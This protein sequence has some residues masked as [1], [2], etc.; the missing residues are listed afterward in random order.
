MSARPLI[1]QASA[2]D[3]A[4]LE[5]SVRMCL[6]GLAQPKRRPDLG[7]YLAWIAGPSA[8]VSLAHFQQVL[9]A[10]SS[11]NISSIF[12]ADLTLS[13]LLPGPEGAA[14][15]QLGTELLGSHAGARHLPEMARLQRAMAEGRAAGHF[16]TVLAMRCIAFHL[17]PRHGLA[18]FAY[19]QWLLRHE[20]A[21]RTF[22][23]FWESHA[24]LILQHPCLHPRHGH[25]DHPRLAAL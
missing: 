7:A 18:S 24:P 11:G 16:A 6:G 12:A 14:S 21:P 17:P 4:E 25:P 13:P 1:Y 9:A 15:L 10:N 2:S 3:P 19:V 20:V 23:H 8:N 5:C 22:C